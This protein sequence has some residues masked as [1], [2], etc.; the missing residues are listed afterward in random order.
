MKVASL[1][2]NCNLLISEKGTIRRLIDQ[3]TECT[4][5][6]AKS[7][8]FGRLAVSMCANF[9]GTY[10]VN[11]EFNNLDQLLHIF[12]LPELLYLFAYVRI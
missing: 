2:G 9:I 1:G 7:G 8:Y 4:L 6:F 5:P 10:N 3:P 12:K 11:R